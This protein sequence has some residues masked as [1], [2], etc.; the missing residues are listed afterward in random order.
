M[1]LLLMRKG[2]N[3]WIRVGVMVLMAGVILAAMVVHF[4]S[5]KL[6]EDALR[7]LNSRMELADPSAGSDPLAGIPAAEVIPEDAGLALLE[8]ERTKAAGALGQIGA[9]LRSVMQWAKGREEWLRQQALDRGSWHYDNVVREPSRWRF[10]PLHVYGLLVD[11]SVL[12]YPDN[13]PGLRKLFLLT[14]YDTNDGVFFTVLTPQAPAARQVATNAAP[15]RSAVRG[16]NLAFDGIFLMAFPFLTGDRLTDMPLFYAPSVRAAA[17][18][19]TP[20]GLVDGR[21]GRPA[22]GEG[23]NKP[24]KQV[25]G[26]DVAYLRSRIYNPPKTGDGNV[27]YASQ[28]GDLRAEK[29]ALVH[30]YEYLAGLS[31][32]RLQAMAKNPE[33]NYVSLM[34]G[35]SAPEWTL[36]EATGFTGVVLSL[37]TLRFPASSDGIDRIYLLTVG[38]LEYRNAGEYTWVVAVLRLPEGLR[39]GD[40]VRADGIFLKLFPYKTGNNAWHWSPLLVSDSVSVVPRRLSPFLP[41]FIPDAAWPWIGAGVGL[42]VLLGGGW[43][44]RNARRDSQKLEGMTRRMRKTAGHRRHP[45]PAHAH[46]RGETAHSSAESAPAEES[47][48]EEQQTRDS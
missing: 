29:T 36:G 25:P 19:R 20:A 14:L 30:V 13:P 21:S 40:R 32:E 12:E 18:G 15:G 38:D 31:P 41:T 42:A 10:L 9:S 5:G 4:R 11:Q 44:L 1:S 34:A 45:V 24:L 8:R 6:S 48:A 43:L 37:Q 3:P 26:L 7:Q 35:E 17:E 27:Q 39:K 22:A 2:E 47:T 16:T 33:V 23:E 28:A 46:S